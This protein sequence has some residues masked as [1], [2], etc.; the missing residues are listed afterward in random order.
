MS[1]RITESWMI[2]Y[3]RQYYLTD[4]QAEDWPDEL[5]EGAIKGWVGGDPFLSTQAVAFQ[6]G[7]DAASELIKL[8]GG[9]IDE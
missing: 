3:F 4:R 1:E 5:V 6:R 9:R 2:A 7:W 8:K